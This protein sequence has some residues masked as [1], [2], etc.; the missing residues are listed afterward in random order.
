MSECAVVGRVS[1]PGKRKN[2]MD[3]AGG[4]ADTVHPIVH[5]AHETVDTVAICAS[6]G[7]HLEINPCMICQLGSTV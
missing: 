6:Y 2:G 5:N 3:D 7:G 1:Y 4:V